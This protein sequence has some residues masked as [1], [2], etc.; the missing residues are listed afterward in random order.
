[1]FGVDFNKFMNS[2]MLQSLAR[3]A[4][5]EDRAAASAERALVAR[6]TEDR[7]RVRE[8]A[9]AQI[10]AGLPK[11]ESTYA[12]AAA[13]AET[14]RQALVTARA[15]RDS[16]AAQNGT[17]RQRMR[18]RLRQLADPKV[19]E[20]VSRLTAR[21]NEARRSGLRWS[22]YVDHRYIQNR[23]LHLSNRRG[24]EAV[25]KAGPVA[26]RALRDLTERHVDDLDAEIARI[27]ATVPW[28]ALEQ[29][30]EYERPRPSE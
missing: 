7:C 5:A 10:E 9:I 16:L 21:V 29:M 13:K 20:A 25:L 24:L 27:E 19:L 14:A 28:A 30:D 2:P 4:D 8:D 26:I 12:A 15:Q 11:L 17:D 23:Y 6:E 18:A 22:E 3:R 1:M